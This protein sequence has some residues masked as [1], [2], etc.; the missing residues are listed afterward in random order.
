MKKL[1]AILLALVLVFTLVACGTAAKDDGTEENAEGN[2]VVLYS[3]SNESILE[4][5]IPAVK[6]ATGLDVDVVSLASGE[7]YA[8]I[9]A[10]R[11]NPQGDVFACSLMEAAQDYTLW[12]QYT[13]IHDAE[14]PEAFRNTNGYVN[15]WDG[16]ASVLIYNT[17]LVDF[18]IKG[19][20][21]LLNPELKGK[22]AFGDA[23]SSNSAYFHLENMLVA[24]SA[25]QQNPDDQSW[26][27]VR[28]FL[29]QLDGKI[30]DSSSAVYKGV[31]SGEYAVGLT[32]DTGALSLIGEGLT[33]VKIVC[34]DEGIIMKTG[35]TAIIK[36]CAHPENAKKLVD[37]LCSKEWAEILGQ[38]PG[39]NV[40]RTD[41]EVSE[42]NDI[43]L[44][45]AKLLNCDTLWSAE[46]KEAILTQYQTVVTEVM[47]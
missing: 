46:H 8:K 5:L 18:E 19:Y 40:I 6:E 43:G 13:S 23:L 11:D 29:G 35:G 30:V 4:A 12:E 22:I 17:D 16:N 3:A 7:L 44:A 15:N 41:V 1:V 26:Q 10:E 42:L 28:D 14:L 25:D 31:A 45:S 20:A 21:D 38:I 34:M 24:M 33:N 9:V 27:F 37:Y 39:G 32:Y 2:T 36:G 47:G